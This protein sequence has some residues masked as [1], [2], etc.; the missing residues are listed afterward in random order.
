MFRLTAGSQAAV[1]LGFGGGT[2]AARELGF[3]VKGAARCEAA[4]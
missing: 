1:R 3:V 2:V 4:G